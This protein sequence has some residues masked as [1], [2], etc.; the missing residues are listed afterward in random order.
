MR[1]RISQLDGH[2][3]SEEENSEEV[4]VVTL[5]LDEVDRGHSKKYRFPL[6]QEDCRS[7]LN[8]TCEATEEDLAAIL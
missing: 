4:S 7:C 5:G 6:C 2:I 1:H 8:N 3:D